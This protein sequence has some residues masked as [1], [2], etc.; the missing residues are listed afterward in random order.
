[1]FSK[2]EWMKVRFERTGGIAGVH[3]SIELDTQALSEKEAEEIY[4]A[5]EETMFLR[6]TSQQG[7]VID[8]FHYQISIET[9]VEMDEDTKTATELKPL[10]DLLMSKIRKDRR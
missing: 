2:M 4:T 7:T 3:D 1:M 10:I 9:R 8:L 5:L 6:A